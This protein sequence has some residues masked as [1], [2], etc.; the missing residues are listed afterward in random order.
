MLKFSSLNKIAN[1]KI[2][3]IVIYFFLSLIHFR[4]TGFPLTF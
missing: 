4:L 2:T 1:H 3:L